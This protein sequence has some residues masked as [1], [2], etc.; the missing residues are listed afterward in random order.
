[1][2]F[3]FSF[4]IAR[5]GSKI[6]QKGLLSCFDAHS[7]AKYK[8]YSYVETGVCVCTGLLNQDI[9]IKFSIT[10]VRIKYLDHNLFLT[11][12]VITQFWI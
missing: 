3:F 11:W 8:S 4:S 10:G 9:S 12:F 2:S 1:M 6:L 7:D 5:L